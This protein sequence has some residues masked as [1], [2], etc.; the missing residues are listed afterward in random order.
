MIISTFEQ[1]KNIIF[2][3]SVKNTGILKN[4]CLMSYNHEND[5]IV[6]QQQLNRPIDIEVFKVLITIEMI[7]KLKFQISFRYTDA[8]LIFTI[9]NASFYQNPNFNV[10]NGYFK[11]NN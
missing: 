2:N 11:F 7:E 4:E 8:L 9:R 1:I 6:I 3:E 5:H 10:N